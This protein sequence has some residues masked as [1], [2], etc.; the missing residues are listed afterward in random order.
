MINEKLYTLY[1][2]FMTWIGDLMVATKP[3]R[4]RSKQILEMLNMIQAGDIICRRYTY[5]LD[6]YLIP[7]KYT[8]SGIVLSQSE[9]IHSVAEGVGI[10]HPMDFVKDC[11][12]F[13]ILRPRYAD[14]N[15]SDKATQQALIYL[16]SA[17]EYDF[18]FNDPTKLYCHELTANCLLAAGLGCFTSAVSFGWH[19][20]QFD[21]NVFLAENLMQVSNIVYEF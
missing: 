18:L 20:F 16:N 4:V 12:G 10:I 5:Y 6:S 21:R 7:G 1:K 3:P 15:H 13:V 17:M 11:D 19:P 14:K 8:H 9:V 2:R